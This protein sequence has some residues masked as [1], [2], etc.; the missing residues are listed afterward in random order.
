VHD[1][2]GFYTDAA[3]STTESEVSMNE[4]AKSA[5]IAM[6]PCDC[7]CGKA[8]AQSPWPFQGLFPNALNNQQEEMVA[9][10]RRVQSE[11][12]DHEVALSNFWLD[13]WKQSESML[14]SW[15]DTQRQLGDAWRRAAIEHVA[16][17]Q[18]PAT[19]SAED[20]LE[21]WRETASQAV[22]LQ[23]QWLGFWLST[24]G[25]SPQPRPASVSADKAS[26][27]PQSAAVPSTVSV[28]RKPAHAEAL[29]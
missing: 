21:T 22:S 5:D 27:A 17:N 19:G 8:S 12:A 7:L 1:P 3:Q 23:N 4:H 25:Q 9:Y 11:I 28:R 2:G 18:V 6:N 24:M 20:V 10:L 13:W 14:V 15:M 29:A 26:G 16:S